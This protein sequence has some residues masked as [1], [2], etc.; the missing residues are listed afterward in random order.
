MYLCFCLQLSTIV[1]S[2][3]FKYFN[4]LNPLEKNI[5]GIQFIV[6]RI[7]NELLQSYG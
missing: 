5:S 1:C 6:I 4:I 2:F 7:L 3:I